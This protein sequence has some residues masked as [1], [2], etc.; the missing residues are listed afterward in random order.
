MKN[1][2]NREVGF[3]FGGKIGPYK[4]TRK[5]LIDSCV[6]IKTGKLKKD[7]DNCYASGIETDVCSAISRQFDSCIKLSPTELE[8]VNQKL[9][10][11]KQ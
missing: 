10:Q 4:P 7:L 8:L 9:N 11:L 3:V 2:T 5:K 1:L 6:A